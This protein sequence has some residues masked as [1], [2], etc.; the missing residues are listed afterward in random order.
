MIIYYYR[1][2]NYGE[3]ASDCGNVNNEKFF[4]SPRIAVQHLIDRVTSYTNDRQFYA[5]DDTIV[6]YLDENGIFDVQKMTQK[7]RAQ[8]V[9]QHDT[10]YIDMLR[11][12]A[13]PVHAYE[14][15][16]TIILSTVEVQ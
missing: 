6:D 12:G 7:L 11:S 4:R 10:I 8:P 1:E 2:E 3:Y 5:S 13:H 9:S 14:S 16:F 15:Y